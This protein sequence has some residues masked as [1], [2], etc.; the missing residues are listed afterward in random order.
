MGPSTVCLTSS[1]GP[2]D[3]SAHSRQA[4]VWSVTHVT[5]LRVGERTQQSNHRGGCSAFTLKIGIPVVR[6]SS[7]H[8]K[9]H[10]F[11]PWSGDRS[12][13]PHGVLHGQ[14]KTKPNNTGKW[15]LKREWN[16]FGW[17]LGC[18]EKW[19][20][21]ARTKWHRSETRIFSRLFH[22]RPSSF[23]G[24]L[25]VKAPQDKPPCSHTSFSMHRDL[26]LVIH[27]RS[28][29]LSPSLSWSPLPQWWPECGHHTS[30]RLIEQ[31]GRFD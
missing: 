5:G 27:I 26:V 31:S 8:C 15:S 3:E 23:F 29:Y 9:G 6:T 19:K 2:G 21:E 10:E 12:Q 18:F 24:S 17:Y 7:F 14:K 30:R 20:M 1:A 13:S 16:F 11:D 22:S 4:L 25:K 28:S